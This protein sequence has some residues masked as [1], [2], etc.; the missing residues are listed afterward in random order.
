MKSAI[1]CVDDERVIVMS[2][3]EQLWEHFGDRYVYEMAMSGEEA[4]EI[5]DELVQDSTKVILIISDWLMNGMKGDELVIRIHEKYPEVQTVMLSGQADPAAIDDAINQGALN[6]F[7]AKPW[8]KAVLMR[9]IS[10]LI[11]T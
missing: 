8:D 3:V 5:V 9:K 7:I 1:I 10:E 2:I 11:E 4:L 6:A